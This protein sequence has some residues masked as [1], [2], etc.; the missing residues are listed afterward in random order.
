MVVNSGVTFREFDY[1]NNARQIPKL[2]DWAIVDTTTPPND[3][4]PGK[5]V[6]AGFFDEDWK[7]TK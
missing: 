5:V 2:P 4:Y 1:T 7:L 3:R 6:T